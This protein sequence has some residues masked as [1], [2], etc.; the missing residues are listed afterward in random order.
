M[1]IEGRIFAFIYV[2][3]LTAVLLQHMNRA[4]KGEL[5]DVREIPALRAIDE[6]I[7]RATETGGAVHFSSGLPALSSQTRAGI[8]VASFDYLGYIARKCAEF[9]TRLIVSCAQGDVYEVSHEM[10]RTSYAQV[11][12][13]DRLKPDTVRY[14]SSEQ[15]A[16]GSA[17]ANIFMKEK[18]VTS[19]MVGGWADEALFVAEAG[20]LAGAVSVGGTTNE[21]Q[22]PM[23]VAACDTILIGDELVVGGIYLSE[24]KVEL[25]AV[26][27][28]DWGKAVVVALLLVGPILATLNVDFLTKLLSW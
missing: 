3:A 6:G 19:V 4:R 16:F 24:E 17:V 23:F 25:G 20:H 28:L 27:A 10:V 18:V 8:T 7:G 15:F 14:L 5:F 11:D 9:D 1:F 22:V 13:L 2:C 26:A 12:A 21:Y